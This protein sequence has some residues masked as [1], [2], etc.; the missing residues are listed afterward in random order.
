MHD[1]DY[2]EDEVVEITDPSKVRQMLNGGLRKLVGCCVASPDDHRTPPRARSLVHTITR[3]ER[4]ERQ[5]WGVKSWP[6]KTACPHHHPRCVV[7]NK[8]KSPTHTMHI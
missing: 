5:F 6:K 8:K 7:G 2:D 1:E 3:V 4:L